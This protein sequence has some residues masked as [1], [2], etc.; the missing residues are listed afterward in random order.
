M[1]W[2]PDLPAEIMNLAGFG[3]VKS[4]FLAFLKAMKLYDYLV[5]SG[6]IGRSFESGTHISSTRKLSLDLA[7]PFK[8][9]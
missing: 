1:V 9:R 7:A 8:L 4:L 5:S 6:S 2:S 3:E